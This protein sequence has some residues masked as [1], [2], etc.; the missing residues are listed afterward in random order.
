LA[1]E[2][3]LRCCGR[4]VLPAPV[5]SYSQLERTSG[6]LINGERFRT[7][8]LWRPDDYYAFKLKEKLA[9]K[10]SNVDGTVPFVVHT[11]A[12]GFRSLPDQLSGSG[13]DRVMVLG[14]SLVF[15]HGVD[16]DQVLA[17]VLMELFA[18]RARFMNFGV[19]GWSLAEYY[20]TYRKFAPVL[21]P[22]LVLMV[23]YTGNDLYEFERTDW[24]GRRQGRLP[25]APLDRKDYTFDSA[26]QMIN[27]G[28]AYK[29]PLLRESH[30]WI[31]LDKYLFAR[32]REWAH[33][34][35]V[36]S[37][38][39]SNIEASLDVIRAISAERKTLV[40][41][42]PVHTDPAPQEFM[43][44][45][46]TIKGAYVLDLHE[47]VSRWKK[48]LSTYYISDGVH[49]TAEGNR[50]LGRMVAD[51]IASE[52]MMSKPSGRLALK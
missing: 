43:Q 35:R 11:N 23:V 24:P 34:Q 7:L 42:I 33:A 29:F 48:Q 14:D 5:H 18:D 1:A 47:A 38:P 41:V 10:V 9:L 16:D 49:F 50:V 40:I 46:R 51:F 28:L 12:E 22:T 44:G 26:G 17:S 32:F 4:V 6:Y 45:V 15:G 39:R 2:A 8:P 20:L 3:L 31:S 52:N 37:Y 36:S 21:D 19:G 27:E 25:S 13:I 30:L